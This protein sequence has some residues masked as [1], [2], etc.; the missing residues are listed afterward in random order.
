MS[1]ATGQRLDRLEAA[2]ATALNI[3]LSEFDTPEQAKARAD[4]AKAAKDAADKLAADQKKAEEAQAA[5]DA[6]EAEAEA[7]RAAA[8]QAVEDKKAGVS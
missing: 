1:D 2:L 6:K 5:A 4:E 3:D 8:R 7:K